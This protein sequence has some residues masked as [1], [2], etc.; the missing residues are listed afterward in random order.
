ME[1]LFGVR[2]ASL[3]DARILV[4]AALGARLQAR[5]GLH[6]GGDYYALRRPDYMLK[7]RENI[8]LDDTEREFDG[9]SEPDFPEFTWLL[10]LEEI[11]AS[12]EIIGLLKGR[13]TT[14]TRLRQ[15][16]DN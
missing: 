14:F 7:L 9:L 10:Y 16:Q 2:A 11:D 6:N 3:D 15:R 12:H 4:E 8:D 1:L 5:E 13:A